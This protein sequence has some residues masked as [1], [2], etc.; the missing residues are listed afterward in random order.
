MNKLARESKRYQTIIDTAA[1]GYWELDNQRRTVMVNKALSAML[2][3]SLEEMRGHTPLAFVDAANAEIFRQQLG[4][5]EESRQRVYNITLQTKDGGELQARFHATTLH[6]PDGQLQGSFAFITDITELLQAREALVAYAR[7]L[8]YSNQELQNFAHIASH[9]LQEPLRTIVSFGDR[10]LLK[11]AEQLDEHGR[12]YLERLQGAAFRMR[13]L[14]EDLLDYSRVTSRDQ[15][16]VELDLDD[17]LAGVLEDLGQRLQACGGRVESD[18]ALGKIVADRGQ[19]HRLLLNLL[20]NALKF[21]EPGTPPRV[22]VSRRELTEQR[23][24]I[25]IEDNG[26]GFDEKYLDRIFRPFQRLHGRSQYQG[27]GMGLAICKK[28][29]ERHHGELQANSTPGLGTTFRIILPA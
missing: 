8:E 23:L 12:E 16:L 17:L 29:V 25:V 14:I 5:R 21:Q 3:Y 11:H 19:M 10:L 4:K 1:E 7:K 24:E 22:R 13:Q 15:R 9:D 2:G 26:I 18:G 28:I 27:T 20:G 6:G